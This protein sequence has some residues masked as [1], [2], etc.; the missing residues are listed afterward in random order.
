MPVSLSDILRA[1]TK[2]AD[3]VSSVLKTNQANRALLASMGQQDPTKKQGGGALERIFGVMDMPGTAVRGLVHNVVSDEDVDIW[4]ELGKAWKGERRV[5]GADILDELGVSNKWAKMLGGFAVD[6]LLDPVTY[7]TMGYGSAGKSG[8]RALVGAL[9]QYGDNVDDV[10]RILGKSADEVL[11]LVDKLREAGHFTAEGIL[12][13]IADPTNIKESQRLLTDAFKLYG[14]GGVKFAGI[15]LGGEAALSKLGFG[16]KA[17][18]R[19]LP[20]TEGLERAFGHG[21]LDSFT[22]I[23]REGNEAVASSARLAAKIHKGSNAFFR[24]VA[25]DAA[26]R[27]QDLL[28]DP[29][30]RFMLTYAYNK[31]MGTP[32]DLGKFTNMIDE[33]KTVANKGDDISGLVDNMLAHREAMHIPGTIREVFTSKEAG[34]YFSTHGVTVTDDLVKRAEQAADIMEQGFTESLSE[35]RAAGLKVNAL[36]G[37][38]AGVAGYTPGMHPVSRTRKQTQT[39]DDFLREF[40]GVDPGDLRGAPSGRAGAGAGLTGKQ[41]ATASDRARGISMEDL[42]G[43]ADEGKRVG[44][45]RGAAISITEDGFVQKGAGLTTEFDFAEL[46]RAGLYKDYAAINGKR[47]AD[48]L[49]ATG[50]DEATAGRVAK[51]LNDAFTDDEAVGGF[52]RIFDKANNMWKR[53]ATILRFPAFGNR[54][55]ISNKIM[56]F[57]EGLFSYAGEK[58]SFELLTRMKLGKPT[59]ADLRLLDDAVRANVFTTFRELSEQVGKGGGSK[60]TQ[61]LGKLNEL[62]ENQSRISAF[63]TA[64]N[65]GL[66]LP[67]AAEMVN[68]ALLDYSDE[69]FSVFERGVAKRL[70][71]FYKWTKGNLTK[72]VRVLAESPGRSTWLGHLKESGE[73]VTDYDESVMPDWFRDTFPIPLPTGG[74]DPTFIST[75][76]LFPQGD[77]EMLSGLMRGK[78][79][80][81]DA[82][83][84]IS[85]LLREPLEFLF[86]KDLWY[87]SPIARYKGEKRR[88]PAYIE[89][90]GD[91]ASGVPG[92]SDVWEIIT[93][94]L[95]IQERDADGEDYYYMNAKAVKLLKDL[96]PWMNNI[97]KALDDQARTPSDRFAFATGVK[98]MLYDTERFAASQAYDDRAA[99]E[100]LLRRMRDEGAQKPQAATLQSLLGGGR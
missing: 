74:K 98:P 42:A 63:V 88:A 1:G 86:N 5:E 8:G 46:T 40:L 27:V 32:E 97:S 30:T 10:A 17:G 96:V 66:S 16:T 65:K 48:E 47:F 79:E 71:P 53:G 56:M 83:G 20:I 85:P 34:A 58:R 36:L 39:L 84:S 60:A 70:M 15:Q 23:F 33:I 6:V 43:L 11:P 50:I 52:F 13:S 81:K 100:A 7:V 22:R 57:Q 92:L 68:K 2:T 29:E 49:V 14:R 80:P 75:A 31:G 77:L 19:K 51:S 18:L 64:Q 55:G 37:E 24:N 95:G 67:A 89:R 72:Q 44:P 54:N 69:A 41:Y 73:A 62:I 45:K 38:G 90:F 26:K 93:D 87:D 91:M 59:P 9:A 76:G 21:A 35:M 12:K 82:F 4:D 78:F 28:P 3:P 94:K 25:D 61:W 99:I